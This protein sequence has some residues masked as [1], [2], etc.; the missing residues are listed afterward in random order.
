MDKV[1]VEAFDHICSLSAGNSEA[2]EKWKTNSNYKVNRR[3]INNRTCDYDSRWPTDSVKVSYSGESKIDDIVKALCHMTG[4]SYDEVMKADYKTEYSTNNTL[5]AYFRSNPTPWG[6]WRAWTF[7]RVRGYKKGTM[8][9]EFLDE[10]VWME[11][12]RRVAKIKGWQL[13]KKTDTNH[14]G[15]ARRKSNK[16][17]LFRD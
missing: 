6:E 7:F 11:F 12:N 5:S 10:S 17:E 4:K 9:F 16:V 1:L 13:P 2:G 8:H 14:K 3:F 15:T